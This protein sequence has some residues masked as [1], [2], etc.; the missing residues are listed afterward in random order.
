[1]IKLLEFL[2]SGCFHNWETIKEEEKIETFNMSYLDGGE[3]T[4][5]KVYPVYIL[6]C[7]NCGHI[8]SVGVGV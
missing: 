1:M 6:R 5:R 3:R 7:K 2:W 8:K 4:T